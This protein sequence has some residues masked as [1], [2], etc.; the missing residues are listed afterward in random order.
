MSHLIRMLELDVELNSE[1]SHT[2]RR[3]T[4]I[5][6]RRMRNERK[7]RLKKKSR[8]VVKHLKH[9][10]KEAHCKAEKD[11]K[12]LTRLSVMARSYWERWRWELQKRKEALLTSTQM[13]MHI[14][15][16]QVA[17]PNVHE[18]KESFLSDPKVN[19]VEDKHYWVVDVSA[20]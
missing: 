7:K 16:K 1:S 12:R 9:E 10:L 18:I 5:E 11:A 3:N 15:S 17:F 6:K 8:A 2:K 20:L 4:I 14:N 19:N 13:G